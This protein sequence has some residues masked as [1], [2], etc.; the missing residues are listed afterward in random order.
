MLRCPISSSIN[1]LECFHE[2]HSWIPG[3]DQIR[4]PMDVIQSKLDR[5]VELGA[6]WDSMT[7]YLLA[8][9]FNKPPSRCPQ[10]NKLEVRD[11]DISGLI[12]FLPNEFPYQVS[13]NHWILWF[14]TIEH[15]KPVITNHLTRL[16]QDY[17]GHDQFD[18]V[19]YEN[20]KMTI[21]G[22]SSPP[23]PSV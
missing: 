19:W 4:P 21:P 10:S 16:L 13:G 15:E 9:V 2:I 7:D 1:V 3:Q 14:G 20:P 11:R 23:S 8:N 6:D 18:F 5:I 12:K 17:L 22:K